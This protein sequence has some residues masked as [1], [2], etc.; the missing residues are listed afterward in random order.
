MPR[1]R[2]VQRSHGHA[3]PWEGA[4]TPVSSRGQD[5]VTLLSGGFR[6]LMRGPQ[7]TWR[8]KSGASARR[9]EPSAGGAE[10]SSR[11]LP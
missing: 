2:R 9:G 4:R 5:P 6:D 7:G 8:G 3:A 1:P 11:D 10:V